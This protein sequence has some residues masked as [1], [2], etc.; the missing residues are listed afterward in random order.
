MKSPKDIAEDLYAFIACADAKLLSRS[1][2]INKIA[3][4]IEA[5]RKRFDEAMQVVDFYAD[6]K[7]WSE[8]EMDGSFK[9]K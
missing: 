3:H 1:A 7:N 4:A 5:E 6:H 9:T 2:A 8:V